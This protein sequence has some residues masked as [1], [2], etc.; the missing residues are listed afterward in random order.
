M[1]VTKCTHQQ[2]GPVRA[3][4]TPLSSSILTSLVGS[5]LMVVLMGCSGGGGTEPPVTI[6]IPEQQYAVNLSNSTN[7]CGSQ[8]TGTFRFYVTTLDGGKSVAGVIDQP[9]PATLNGDRLTLSATAQVENIPV[10]IDL[11]WV[12]APE[13]HTF[14]G[15]TTLH[16]ASAG[17][18]CS[19]TYATTGTHDISFDAPPTTDPTSPDA[20]M[21]NGLQLGLAMDFPFHRSSI[22][23]LSGGQG[24]WAV[25]F[26]V[27]NMDH[28]PG[29]KTF[30][31]SVGGAGGSTTPTGSQGLMMGGNL[32]WWDGNQYVYAGAA[33]AQSASWIYTPDEFNGT[34]TWKWLDGK[35]IFSLQHDPGAV[36]VFAPNGAEAY[37]YASTSWVWGRVGDTPGFSTADNWSRVSCPS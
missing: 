12:F 14:Q 29:N 27:V 22:S 24:Y 9:A 23:C 30:L 16:A 1:N 31:I 11:D 6:P 17:H 10:T 2:S 15:T 33:Y 34:S 13:R 32:A 4:V 28:S 21:S 5:A 8:N 20:T 18:S 35:W 7:T 3:A 36:T 19:F 37:L 26:H 25:I